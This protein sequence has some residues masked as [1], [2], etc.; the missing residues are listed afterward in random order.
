MKFHEK[1]VKTSGLP[2]SRLMEKERLDVRKSLASEFEQLAEVETGCA[3]S[4]GPAPGTGPPP[5]TGLPPGTGPPSGPGPPLGTGPFLPLTAPILPVLMPGQMDVQ[6]FHHPPTALG[7]GCHAS[8]APTP[9]DGCQVPMPG[10]SPS[11]LQVTGTPSSYNQDLMLS[12]NPQYNRDSTTWPVGWSEARP[13]MGYR[14][15]GMP[16]LPSGLPIGSTSGTY[17]FLAL[18]PSP[19]SS[20]GSVPLYQP[21]PQPPSPGGSPA[22]CFHCMQY[23]AVFTIR[24]V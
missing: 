11:F 17:N 23:G 13:M 6:P 20:I 14:W 1:L 3:P 2:P 18:S 10:C 19:Q 7:V 12:S 21:Q 8:P 15:D 24:P 4:T 22:Y 5:G 9:T 16:L